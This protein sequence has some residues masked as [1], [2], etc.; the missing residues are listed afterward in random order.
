MKAA[1]LRPLYPAVGAFTTVYAAPAPRRWPEL[2]KELARAGVRSPTLDA[3]ELVLT[4][5]DFTSPG[6]AVFARDGNVIGTIALRAAPAAALAR[7]GPL[8]HLRH[9]LAD[10]PLLDPVSECPPARAMIV[11]PADLTDAGPA[12]AGRSPAPAGRSP[13]PGGR[14]PAPGGR[15]PA[16]GG[17]SPA[18]GGRFPAPAGRSP[19]P[20][21]AVPGGAVPGGAVPGGA[22]PGGA[23]PA[24][25][26]PGGAAPGGAE[27]G[28]AVPGGAAPGGAEPAGAAPGGAE[29]AATVQAGAVPGRDGGVSALVGAVPVGHALTAVTDADA[30]RKADDELDRRLDEWRELLSCGQATQGI[31]PTMAA[32]RDSRAATVFLGSDPALA[33][34]A[35][36][37]SAGT[38]LAASQAELAQAGLLAPLRDRTDEA[39][40]RAAAMTDA[41]LFVLAAGSIWAGDLTDGVAA[42][43]RYPI[44]M[45]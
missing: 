43:L 34:P 8:P 26:V 3:I 17:R 37:G 31:G 27:P 6:H 28:G 42:I 16:P 25:S 32:L 40:I 29:P 45:S 1:V 9:V 11:N 39:I 18:P 44:P 15:S 21:G 5:P 4:S 10:A 33:E 41:E 35:W 20:A 30:L 23:V 24:G 7:V 2:R 36:L 13:A 14:S 38:E 19:A 12:P 22:V